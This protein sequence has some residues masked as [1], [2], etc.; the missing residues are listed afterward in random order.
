MAT[1]MQS[2]VAEEPVGIVISRG[3][4]AEPTPTFLAYVWGPAPDVLD[5]IAEQKA[6]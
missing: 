2:V 1:Q 6:A 4:R 3:K 5:I